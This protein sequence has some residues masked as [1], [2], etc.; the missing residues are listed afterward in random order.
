MY[1]DRPTITWTM[2][3]LGKGLDYY[4]R[5]VSGTFLSVFS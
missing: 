5:E 3:E 4:K 2:D 1:P